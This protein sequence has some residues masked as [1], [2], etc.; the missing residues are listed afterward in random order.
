VCDSDID[1]RLDDFRKKALRREALCELVLFLREIVGFYSWSP[2][3]KARACTTKCLS[4]VGPGMA[5]R[6]AGVVFCVGG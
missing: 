5:L 6:H 4:K 3:G 1:S 2:T